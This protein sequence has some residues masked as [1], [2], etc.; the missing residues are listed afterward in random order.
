LEKRVATKPFVNG[1][2]LNSVV[3]DSEA[4]GEANKFRDRKLY[5]DRLRTLKQSKILKL[6]VAVLFKFLPLYHFLR[7]IINIS[8]PTFSSL[9]AVSFIFSPIPH[10]NHKILFPIPTFHLLSIFHLLTITCGPTAIGINSVVG[11]EQ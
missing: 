1:L 10:Y 9:A 6:S 3:Y 7:H 11:Y 4:R 5:M 2:K 8:S